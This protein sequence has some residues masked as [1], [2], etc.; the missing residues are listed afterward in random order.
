[1]NT[2]PFREC[3]HH[4]VIEPADGPISQGICKNCGKVKEFKNH[5]PIPL[6]WREQAAN[7]TGVSD[8]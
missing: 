4:W 2:T 7:R 8:D 6:N 3:S 1:M 5:T